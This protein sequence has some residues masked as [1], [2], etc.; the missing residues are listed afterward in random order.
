M[1]WARKFASTMH[2]IPVP[3]MIAGSTGMFNC[4]SRIPFPRFLDR[5]SV[6]RSNFGDHA[7]Q[8]IERWHLSGRNQ[9]S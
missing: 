8:L 1:E 7:Q 6:F 5:R 9:A 3:N 4:M 2:E